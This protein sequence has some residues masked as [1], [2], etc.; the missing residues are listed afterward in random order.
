ML[1]DFR[2]DD[3]QSEHV[4][5]STLRW[6]KDE[7]F[8]V[9]GSA[10]GAFNGLTTATRLLTAGVPTVVP[11]ANVTI[12]EERGEVGVLASW[13]PSARYGLTG[14]MKVET[15]R[16]TAAGDV[17][18]T[19]TLT[20]AKPRLV[21]SFTPDKATQLRLRGEREVGQISFPALLANSEFNSGVVRAGN[22]N[23]RPQ[24]AWVVEAVLERQFWTGASAVVTLRQ[25]AVEDVVDVR[26]VGTTGAVG[27]GNIG[28]GTQTE[29]VFVVT[30]PLKAIGVNGAMLT[31]SLN[32]IWNRVTDPTPNGWE[33]PDPW[34]RLLV[35]VEYRARPN[36][37]ARIEVNNATGAKTLLQVA[38][39]AGVRDRS[40]LLYLDRRDLGIA[41]YAFLRLRRTF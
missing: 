34:V 23:L 12:N 24:R 41:P 14:A 35:F 18:L 30:L 36:L 28:D 31:G 8:T 37:I 15:S 19:R 6:K 38:S 17:D 22:P 33:G 1:T 26:L 13:K 16:L 4:L 21:L 11:A 25:K 29:A 3:Q 20:Y 32:K 10:E 2:V 7:R 39:F 27:L 9:E 5:R 40:A